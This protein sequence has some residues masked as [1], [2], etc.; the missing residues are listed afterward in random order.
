MRKIHVLLVVMTMVVLAACD[1]S[2]LQ[3]L[4]AGLPRTTP[5]PEMVKVAVKVDG[6]GG[7]SCCEK[8]GTPQPEPSAAKLVPVTFVIDPTPAPTPTPTVTSTPGSLAGSGSGGGGSSPVP[9]EKPEWHGAPVPKG[10][11]IPP[12]VDL[13]GNWDQFTF[14]NDQ[15]TIAQRAFVS[16]YGNAYGGDKSWYTVEWGDG[17]VSPLPDPL[18]NSIVQD[19]YYRTVYY[20]RNG[21]LEGKVV[22]VVASGSHRVRRHCGTLHR[23][24]TTYL[25]SDWTVEDIPP[26]K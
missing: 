25:P 7:S 1:A 21:Y 26:I 19:E 5:S 13:D 4:M 10:E 23:V 17:T 9:T 2:T 20:Y 11:M 24:G 14:E 18:Y 3:R 16:F 12:V 8:A 15:K 6:D 22:C